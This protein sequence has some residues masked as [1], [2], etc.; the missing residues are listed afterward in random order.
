[1]RQ[2]TRRTSATT[3]D[4]SSKSE[5]FITVN[6]VNEHDVTTPTDGNN[7]NEIDENANAGTVGYG[8]CADADGTTNTAADQ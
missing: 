3:A 6:D 4:G 8:F 1:M 5:I 7:A 2:A